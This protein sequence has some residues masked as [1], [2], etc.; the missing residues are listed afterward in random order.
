MTAV[1]SDFIAAPTGMHCAPASV[2]ILSAGGKQPQRKGR[3]M[4][5]G[6]RER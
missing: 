1:T 5:V 3:I 2:G 6:S 4:K